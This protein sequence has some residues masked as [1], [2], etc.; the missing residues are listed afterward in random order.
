MHGILLATLAT[1]VPICRLANVTHLDPGI[2]PGEVPVKSYSHTQPNASYYEFLQ[3]PC[4]DNKSPCRSAFF[5]RAPAQRPAES[6]AFPDLPGVAF[7]KAQRPVLVV[8]PGCASAAVS[9]WEKIDCETQLLHHSHL[10]GWHVVVPEPTTIDIRNLTQ[11][12][13][14]MRPGYI[15]EFGIRAGFNPGAWAEADGCAIKLQ[16]V[17]DVRYFTRLL[18]VL[19]E[20]ADVDA[21]QIFV[22][23]LSNGANMLFNLTCTLSHRVAGFIGSQALPIRRNFHSR[24]KQLGK[25]LKPLLLLTGTQDATNGQQQINFVKLQAEEAQCQQHRVYRHPH[26]RC[27]VSQGCV[28]AQDYTHCLLPRVAHRYAGDGCF[29]SDFLFSAVPTVFKTSNYLFYW[30]QQVRCL[31][32]D[33]L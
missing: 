7:G 8:I 15:N 29:H 1:L 26:A 30:V 11:E 5:Q 17:D 23:G 2:R 22:L 31:S 33:L 19:G 28:G 16:H 9:Y 18:D 6:L 24:C 21:S 13:Q 14:S 10:R 12:E 27:A 4:D 32:H 25:Q 3:L 20:R